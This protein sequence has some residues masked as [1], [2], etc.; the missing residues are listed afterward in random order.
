VR[1]W[2]ELVHLALESG[3][4]SVYIICR[5]YYGLKLKAVG[6]NRRAAFLIAFQHQDI[7]VCLSICG[8]FAGLAGATQVL[9][10][11]HR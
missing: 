5:Y 7:D 11:Y 2:D 10:V 3:D 9:A 8:A 4:Y 6:K 1:V